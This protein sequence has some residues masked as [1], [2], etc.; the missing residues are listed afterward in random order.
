MDGLFNLGMG[1]IDHLME[2]LF[3]QNQN[4]YTP[5]T[6]ALLA[7]P[8]TNPPP[9][10][11]PMPMGVQTPVSQTTTPNSPMSGGMLGGM[12]GGMDDDKMKH[13][14]AAMS[15]INN[16]QSRPAGQAPPPMPSVMPPQPF[17]QPQGM[18]GGQSQALM[19]LLQMAGQR[20]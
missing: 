1:G 19:Q 15:L 8:N 14:M 5:Q 18:Q 4:Q 16:S 13:L 3:G 7:A 17:G 2:R 9:M 11:G 20:R 10:G 6:D 12:G